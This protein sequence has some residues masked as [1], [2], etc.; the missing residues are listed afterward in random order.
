MTGCGRSGTCRSASASNR[1]CCWAWSRSSSPAAPPRSGRPTCGGWRR[2]PPTRRAGGQC[3]RGP[4]RRRGRGP[5]GGRAHRGAGRAAAGHTC[6]RRPRAG[7]A[8]RRRRPG[9]DARIEALRGQVYPAYA[10]FL[11]VLCDDL[12]RAQEALGW[13]RGR[14]ARR[15]TAA[16][17]SAGR[18]CRWSPTPCTG[19]AVSTSGRCR[20]T[21]G[22]G[23]PAG[24]RRP[25]RGG[26]RAR[27]P[28]GRPAGVTGGDPGARPR[29][30]RPLLGCA[31]RLVR[32]ASRPQL[33]RD[34]GRHRARGRSGRLLPCRDR[35]SGR[36]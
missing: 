34:A 30:G 32:P 2:S 19:W 20:T 6:G 1:G 7:A 15:S 3:S 13:E 22:A 25:G 33:R 17:S 26:R 18:P 28:A 11:E 31:A 14:A 23:A 21:D 10:R 16:R 12:P 35:R 24:P 5:G 9:A 4:R 27:G 36:T 8:G 29:P